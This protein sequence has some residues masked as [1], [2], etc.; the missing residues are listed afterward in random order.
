MQHIDIVV[1]CESNSIHYLTMLGCVHLE[2]ALHYERLFDS[3]IDERANLPNHHFGILGDF[4]SAIIASD[5]KR[6][7]AHEASPEVAGRTDMQNAALELARRKLRRIGEQLDMA[8]LG[9]HEWTVTQRYG[10]DPISALIDSLRSTGSPVRWGGYC[11]MLTYHFTDKASYEQKRKPHHS[12]QHRNLYHHGVSA[13]GKTKAII[14]TTEWSRQQPDFDICWTAHTH[15]MVMFPDPKGTQ[16]EPRWKDGQVL[17]RHMKHQIR[18]FVNTGT[19][20]KTYNDHDKLPDFGERGGHP[21]RHIGAPLVVIKPSFGH[22]VKFDVIGS[23]E[24][25]VIK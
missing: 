14:P 10:F 17:Q 19:F 1:P 13:G 22:G 20:Q 12:V 25:G 4:F 18:W 11:G 8:A 6:Y 16:S 21:L 15:A 23:T 5:Q 24:T 3:L 2:S 9:N 7:A